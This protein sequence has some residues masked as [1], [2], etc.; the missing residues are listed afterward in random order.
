MSSIS[1]IDKNLAV[2]TVLNKN[3]IAFYD[4]RREPFSIY[5]LYDCKDQPVFCRLPKEI[6]E[7]TNDG[8]ATLYKHTAGGRV[9]FSTDSELICIKAT[10]NNVSLFPHMPASGAAGFDLFIASPDG[11][12]SR[13]VKTFMP[14]W[15]TV[16]DGYESKI[17]LNGKKMRHYTIN[18]PSYSGVSNLWIGISTGSALAKGLQYKNVPPIVYYGSSITQGGCSSRPGNIYQNIV[19]R[20]TN[21]DYINLGFSGSGRGEDVIADYMA[22][23]DMCAFVSD[24]DHNAP[25]PQHLADTHYK[26]YGKIRATHPSIPYIMLSKC[27]VDGNYSDS[28]KRRDVIYESYLEARNNG[29]RNVYFIDG[30]SIFRGP[31]ENMCTVDSCHPNDLGFALIADAI[32]AELN[33]AFTQSNF[34]Q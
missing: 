21:I 25:S 29:D 1:S 6:A 23:L 2:E 9:R 17:E 15:H 18:F 19:C 16:D 10:M 7:A 13:Y 5:G 30:A 11:F 27:D 28:L 24:Y 12:E 33:R 22:S 8:V 31:Y 4:V 26:L 34:N 3:G 20:K 14:P 32:T